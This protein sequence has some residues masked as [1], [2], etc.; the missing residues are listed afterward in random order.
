MTERKVF[1][2]YANLSENKLK[3]KNNK[4]VYANNDVMTT[5]ITNCRG[6]KRR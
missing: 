2:K 1:E 3:T 4:E 6:E 5:V